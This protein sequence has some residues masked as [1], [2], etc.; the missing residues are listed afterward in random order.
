M[1]NEETAAGPEMVARVRE[2]WA[3]VLDTTA[4][5]VPLDVNF[6]DAGGNSMLLVLLSDVL[7]ETGGGQVDAVDLFQ[8]STVTAQA[9]LL[10]VAGGARGVDAHG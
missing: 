1:T 7:N 10:A 5:A 4:D 6:F 3:E 2:A 8:H 9:R